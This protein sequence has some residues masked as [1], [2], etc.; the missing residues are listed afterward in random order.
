MIRRRSQWSLPLL[1]FGLALLVAW[2][3]HRQAVNR[4]R[5][6]AAQTDLDRCRQ[7]ADRIQDLSAKPTRAWLKSDS[8]RERLALHIQQ[9]AQAA[10]INESSIVSIEPLKG[11]QIGE[12]AYMDELTKLQLR[13]LSLRQLVTFLKEVSA[14]QSG[15]RVD[16]LRLSA[17]RSGSD[18]ADGEAEQRKRCPYYGTTD[19]SRI[20]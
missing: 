16:S 10:Q 2:S 17:P 14:G 19:S 11:H 18:S 9:A 4:R 13:N 6:Q 7:L 1:F 15:L 20:C 5:I 3:S 8:P 12:S